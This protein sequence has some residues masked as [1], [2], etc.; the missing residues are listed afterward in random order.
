MSHLRKY[1]RTETA[2]SVVGS[3]VVS[4][5]FFLLVFGNS[6]PLRVWGVGAYAFDF[7]P[8]SFFTALLCTWLPGF[9]T[10]KRLASGSL[11]WLPIQ[12]VSV[13]SVLV[14]GLKYAMLTL[15]IGAGGVAASLYLAGAQ[16]FQWAPGLILKLCFGAVLAVIITP[17]GLR[18]MLRKSLAVQ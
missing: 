12:Q 18:A 8:Q 4:G 6:G 2:L 17:I 16:E 15:L 1:I 3:T 7:I 10:R 9:L 5:L 13:T 11:A 14:R